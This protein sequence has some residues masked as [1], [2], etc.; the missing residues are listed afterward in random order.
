MAAA[1]AILG[2]LRLRHRLAGGRQCSIFSLRPR[3]DLAEAR[4]R[5]EADG[6]VCLRN[7]F[8]AAAVS[9]LRSAMARVKASSTSS[10]RGVMGVK[11]GWVDKFL[12][13][14]EAEYRAAVFDPRLTST[15]AHLLRSKGLNL[16]YDHTCVKEAGDTAATKWHHDINYLPVEP[17]KHFASAWIAL[18][19]VGAQQGRLE[20]VRGSHR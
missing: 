18:D 10:F 6:V 15:V 11:G 1:A 20:F 2:L 9:G 17:P 16:L 4:R 3:G 14:S 5:Y 7:V 19:R 8:D 12:W 13:R